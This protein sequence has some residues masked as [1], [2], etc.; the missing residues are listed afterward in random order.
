MRSVEGMFKAHVT[1]HAEEDIA[2]V[3]DYLLAQDA[4]P[5]AVDLWQRFEDAFASL[6]QY[7]ARGHVP[8]ELLEYPD[9]RIREL[10]VGV[11]RLIYRYFDQDVYILFVAD[12][13]R[14]I[15]DALVDRVLRFA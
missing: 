11:Y 14:N 6:K 9:K 12:G 5:A 8:P 15:Q 13:R 4:V 10:H 2:A 7:P 3:L 1:R